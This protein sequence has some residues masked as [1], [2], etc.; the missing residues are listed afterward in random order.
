MAL[1]VPQELTC[2]T[3]R[4]AGS[5]CAAQSQGAGA[6]RRAC[7]A[8]AF[9]PGADGQ[10]RAR[11]G[12]ECRHER[13]VGARK[14]AD[15]A[16]AQRRTEGGNSTWLPIVGGTCARSS[17][18]RPDGAGVADLRGNGLELPTDLAKAR[19]ALQ[20]AGAS[21]QTFTQMAEG[22]R[23]VY[24]ASDLLQALGGMDG[25]LLDLSGRASPFARQLERT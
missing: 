12:T 2:R 18:C 22:G 25:A 20:Q 14:S 19:K 9:A 11:P 23:D 4:M 5:G 3:V 8:R 16:A 17:A 7:T 1:V 13:A 24:P 6:S 21:R 15:R 10:N